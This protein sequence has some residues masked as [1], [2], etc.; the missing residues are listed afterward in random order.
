MN[1]FGIVVLNSPEDIITSLF[2]IEK[3]E[4]WKSVQIQRLNPVVG[5]R[6]MNMLLHLR[7]EERGG[8]VRSLLF[9]YKTQLSIRPIKKLKIDYVLNSMFIYGKRCLVF[10]NV[11]RLTLTYPLFAVRTSLMELMMPNWA[12]EVRQEV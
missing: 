7:G 3:S 12:I 6:E 10:A 2:I 9:D 1:Q 11:P 8:L 5:L 4:D